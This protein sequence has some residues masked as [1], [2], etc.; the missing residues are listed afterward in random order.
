MVPF[1]AWFTTKSPVSWLPRDQCWYRLCEYLPFKTVL[2]TFPA[3]HHQ[4]SVDICSG[5]ISGKV[6]RCLSRYPDIVR[7]LKTRYCKYCILMCN[8]VNCAW[9]TYKHSVYFFICMIGFEFGVHRLLIF[10][11][12]L[13]RVFCE[14]VE[15]ETL[16]FTGIEQSVRTRSDYSLTSLKNWRYSYSCTPTDR[17]STSTELNWLPVLYS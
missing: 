14:F 11:L 2:T 12:I 3:L 17:V 5:I 4:P 13:G 6:L 10:K 8:I 15:L 7:T 16:H 1:S 9:C